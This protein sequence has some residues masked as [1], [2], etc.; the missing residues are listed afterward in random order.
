MNFAE[1]R[2]KILA[3]NDSHD[4]SA[5]EKAYQFAEK[6]HCGQLR[7]SG[8]EYIQHPMA[9]AA[10]LCDMEMDDVSIMAAFL[11]DVAED[12]E[13]T[14]ED[15]RQNFGPEVAQIVDGVTKLGK[16]AFRDK[17]EAQV[18]NLRKMF[19]AMAKDIRVIIIKLA[20]RLHN[21]RTLQ[22]QRE[23]KQR[24]IAKETMDIYAPLANRL[25]IYRIKSEL[26]DLSFRYLNPEAFAE[27]S[28]TVENV[29]ESRDAQI[30]EVIDLLTKRLFEVGIKAE[31]SGRAK[32]L[33]SI[34]RKMQAQEK[35][36]SEIF[37]L[38]AI[39][40]IVDT[41]NDCYGALG[42]VHIL[43]KPIPG[44]FKDYIAMPKPN[45]YQSLHTILAGKH[46]EPFEIQIRT[47]EMHHTAVYGVA[48][49]WK[50]KEGRRA[51]ADFEQKL[52]WL[53]QLLEWQ[54]DS[55]DAGEFLE[56]LKVDL[57]DDTV[58]AFTPKGDVL[59]LPADSCLIDFA[60]RVHSDVG[61]NCIGAKVNGR[62]VPLESTLQNGDIVEIITSKTPTGPSR[63]WVC[64]V[65][66]SQAK[67][68][69]R[70]WFRK[71]KREENIARGKDGLEREARKMGM[72]TAKE[73]K[74]ENMLELARLFRL[75]SLD[76][77]YAALGDGAITFRRALLR[78]KDDII[79]EEDDERPFVF[80]PGRTAGSGAHSQQVRV[81]GMANI[82]VRFSHCCNP[83]PGDGVI[84]YITRGRGV[85]V[86]KTVCP[87][88][89]A[90][91]KRG[92]AE[93]LIEVE[94]TAKLET[95]DAVY[96]VNVDILA[97]DR[98]ALVTDVLNSLMET[99]TH[100]LNLNAQAERDGTAHI[101]L[102][103]E[104]RS[105]DHLSFLLGRIRRIKE[106]NSVS[107]V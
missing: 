80:L 91:K 107:R 41:V 31:L 58:F 72:D 53:R 83:L 30:A 42:V 85:S 56:S 90:L 32:H 45:M 35:G 76:D 24:E 36:L 46:G 63:D 70:Q 5:I 98:P 2:Q 69:I 6:A 78:L 84:G 14:L 7:N 75:N 43:W 82:G 9:V 25:G 3:I 47:W 38:A 50:Y 15:I 21:M 104:T 8:E 97:A 27:L 17:E 51:E 39:R 88:I 95:E 65:K 20:D 87:E 29:K 12:T 64:K 55:R 99:K 105:V 92:E 71:E 86:H 13:K 106:V 60:Y 11:H 57:F 10:I 59:E 77:L 48:A 33:Y 101:H 81:K 44:K 18:E 93:R 100:V 34:Y 66:T 61:H 37:D 67:N 52:S 62:I 22:Y 74:K 1:L 96:P 40:V 94:W 103:I 89:A 23:D 4:L 68:R 16:I 79:K 54:H 102:K 19:L 28:R 26:E 73:L 49:H